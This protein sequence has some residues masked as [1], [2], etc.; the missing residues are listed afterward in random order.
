MNSKEILTRCSFKAE[1]MTLRETIPTW[2]KFF[3]SIKILF[4][5]QKPFLLQQQAPLFRSEFV[6]FYDLLNC[7][8]GWWMHEEL[9]MEN[10]RAQWALHFSP[11]PLHRSCTKQNIHSGKF[12]LS[13]VDP[14]EPN[15]PDLIMTQLDT[16][17]ALEVAHRDHIIFRNRWQSN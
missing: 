17:G 4:A 10:W 7:S 16:L 14:P 3:S 11:A 13:E 8:V 9:R 15:Q 6:S 12:E 2:I 1:A 5:K